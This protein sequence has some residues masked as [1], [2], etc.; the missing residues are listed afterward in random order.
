MYLS[1][2]PLIS[3]RCLFPF[4]LPPLSLSLSLSLIFLR[5][6]K[7]LQRRPLF[8]S[9]SL[10]IQGSIEGE[11]GL[12]DDLSGSICHYYALP[13]RPDGHSTDKKVNNHQK[14]LMTTRFIHLTH[15]LE[16]H[17]SNFFWEDKSF[18]EKLNKT[19]KST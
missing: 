19:N 12:M 9:I 1:S 2:L 15:S 7:F 11:L 10:V 5:H 8:D 13:P 18:S 3:F 16:F 14:T 17:Q 6:P 4:F